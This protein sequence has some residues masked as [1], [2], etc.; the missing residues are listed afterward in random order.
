M[1]HSW[2]V[3]GEFFGSLLC[4]CPSPPTHSN[5]LLY[6]TPPHPSQVCLFLK[7][8]A[9]QHALDQEQQD[10]LTIAVQAANADIVTLLRLA[11]MAEEMREAEAPP[12]QPGPLPGSSPTELQYRRC[13]QEFIGLHLEES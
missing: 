4:Y 7:R 3:P 6:P 2:A 1:L 5:K 12:G 9:D 13:I 11:R 8:G 10:P